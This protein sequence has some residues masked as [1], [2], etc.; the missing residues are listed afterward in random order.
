MLYDVD[1]NG[2]AG[3]RVAN[4]CGPRLQRGIAEPV[5]RERKVA[6]SPERKF[7]GTSRLLAHEPRDR[8]RRAKD[9]ARALANERRWKALR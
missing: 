5:S 9:E 6:S 7:L 2:M 8:I 4:K 1:G 3:A